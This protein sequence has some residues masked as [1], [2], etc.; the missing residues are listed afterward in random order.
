MS[1]HWESHP[2]THVLVA[3][4]MG[5]EPKVKG[6]QKQPDLAEFFASVPQKGSP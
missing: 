3:S 1:E 4:F 6:P 2:P 5:F